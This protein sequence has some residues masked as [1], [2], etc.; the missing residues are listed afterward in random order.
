MKPR[1]LIADDEPDVLMLV[2]SNFASA[3]FDVACAP[4]GTAAL[5]D[6]RREVPALIVLDIMMPGLTGIEVLRALKRES[7]TAAIP[8]ILLSARCAEVDRVLGFELG[9]D[10]FVRKPFS[11]RELVLRARAILQRKAR[12]ACTTPVIHVGTIELDQDRHVASVE[13]REVTLTAI[14]FKLLAKLAANA[15]RVLQREALIHD[16]WGDGAEVDA[17]TVD[18]HVRRL[19]AKLAAAGQ[20][21][22]TARGFGYRL[23]AE[24]SVEEDSSST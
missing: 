11:P 9:A 6:A 18:T 24:H 20:Q 23:D 19:R 16:I 5:A 1:I 4:D 22:Q 7:A 13:G 17:R 2:G 3:G 8:V 10:D 15:G 12:P 14:E 21:I